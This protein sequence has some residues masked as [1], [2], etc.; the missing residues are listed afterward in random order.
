[1]NEYRETAT[2]AC[3]A[4]TLPR[5]CY[6]SPD[7]LAEEMEKIRRAA[8]TASAASIS[9]ARRLLTVDR[10]RIDHRAGDGRALWALFNDV[11]HRGTHLPEEAGRFGETIQ[12]SYHAWTYGTDGRLI[13]APHMQDAEGF[14][15]ADYPLH[16]AAIAEW[17]GF[18]FVNVARA[19]EPFAQAWAPMIGRLSR[20]GLPSLEVGHRVRYEV[21]ANWKLVFRNY[22]VSALP[23]D[24]S[25]ARHRA[26]HQS[27]D[28]PWKVPSSAAIWRS[29][30]Q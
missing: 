10:G 1:V 19:P 18:L 29:R 23:H 6:V 4:C 22:P 26:A 8:G 12:C 16:A 17:E 13:G 7:V 5:E 14:D 25:Q 2:S 3:P 15:K 30:P 27:E 20:F 9:A 21:E 24:P 11:P 28:R